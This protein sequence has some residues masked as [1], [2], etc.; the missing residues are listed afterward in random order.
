MILPIIPHGI[1]GVIWYQGESNTGKTGEYQRLLT[2]LINDWRTRWQAGAFPFLIVQLANYMQPKSE[3]SESNWAELREAQLR[4]VSS[5]K[6]TGLA[7]TIDIGETNDV[8]PLNKK[9]V[10]NRLALAAGKISYGENNIVYSGPLYRSM[11]VK[12]NKAVISFDHIGSGLLAKG[13]KPLSQFAVAGADQ[14][15]VWA[16][17]K[18][19]GDQVLVWSDQI[20]KPIAVR[21]AW[22]N[23]PL[24]C[25]LYNKEGLPASP[26]RTD[27][28]PRS[29]K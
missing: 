3:P 8:H 7:V 5:V 25:N 18:I 2:T 14:K 24:G 15:F 13:N 29:V 23:N 6:N 26:F 1:R 19:E 17:A 27:S 16:N 10:G 20:S 22:A 28:W 11:E 12:G 21:Y 4:V 9:D